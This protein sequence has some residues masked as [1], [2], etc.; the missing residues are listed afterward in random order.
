[1]AVELTSEMPAGVAEFDGRLPPLD[2]D[3]D[4]STGIESE[5]LDHGGI[6]A[7]ITASATQ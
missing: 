2:A 4:D 5:N 3:V 6:S 7:G 1:M